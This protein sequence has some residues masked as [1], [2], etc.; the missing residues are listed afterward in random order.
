MI[1]FQSHFAAQNQVLVLLIFFICSISK[2]IVWSLVQEVSV[3]I[4]VYNW[5]TITMGKPQKLTINLV[6]TGGP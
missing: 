3:I 2:I 4:C 6:E 1:S 5:K